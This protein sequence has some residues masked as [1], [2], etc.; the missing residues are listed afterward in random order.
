MSFNCRDFSFGGNGSSSAATCIE[1]SCSSNS[2][3]VV[4]LKFRSAV[5][6]ENSYSS[7]ELSLLGSGVSLNFEYEGDMNSTKG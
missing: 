2:P 3:L 6:F 7:V 1:R 4:P 5:H